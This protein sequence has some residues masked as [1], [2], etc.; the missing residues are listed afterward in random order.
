MEN[1]AKNARLDTAMVLAQEF[2]LD[3]LKCP[4]CLDVFTGPCLMVP[5]SHEFCEHCIG[6]YLHRTKATSCPLCRGKIKMVVN[7][8]KVT[9]SLVDAYQAQFPPTT[10]VAVGGEAGVP[11]LVVKKN[12]SLRKGHRQLFEE[13]SSSSS[14]EEE[15]GSEDSDDENSDEEDQQ[16]T[17][18]QG[19]VSSDT[20]ST[21]MQLTGATESDARR[22]V[23]GAFTRGLS[24]DHAVEFYFAAH[25][26][27]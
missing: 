10:A 14:S 12:V 17:A 13:A 25:S 24:L 26:G 6:A 9:T 21:F 19:A 20:V 8:S 16:E 7:S 11:A 1:S 23:A 18:R 3:H 5:C 22:T 4:I 27:A 15:E 2:F